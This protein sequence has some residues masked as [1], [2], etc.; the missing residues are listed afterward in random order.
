MK[1]QM[2]SMIKVPMTREEA[3]AILNV[4]PNSVAAEGSEEHDPSQDYKK[5]ME[6]FEIL[7]EKNLPEN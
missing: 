2:G 4:Q 1:E 7:Y 5:I 3:I 6:R